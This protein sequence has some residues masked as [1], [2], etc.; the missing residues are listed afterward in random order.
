MELI[1]ASGSPYRRAQLERLGP[2]FRSV[3]PGVDEAP[4]K[5][6][7][8]SPRR[9]AEQLAEAKARAV[10]E[11]EAEAAVIGADQLVAFQGLVL[12]KPGTPER[13]VDQLLQL[14][15]REH[16]LITA[17]VVIAPGRIERGMEV[18]R[19][20]LRDLTAEEARR[21]VEADRSWDC[22]GA[23]K[24][25]ARGVAL[26][27][28]IVCEDHSAIVGLPLIALTTALRRLGFPIP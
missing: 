1:L 19:I 24:W 23:Y 3:E 16:Q 13:A 28:R 14:S 9:L 12:G 18:A 5:A 4:L 15:G 11:R 8:L 22:A 27:E 17:F 7:G 25:E 10:A 26:F 20:R 21:Y 6:A 2:P